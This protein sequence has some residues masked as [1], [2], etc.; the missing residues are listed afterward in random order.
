AA[1]TGVITAVVAA[2]CTAPFMAAAAGAA[3]LLAVPQALLVFAVM[4]LGLAFPYCT[5]AVS[6]SL[7]RRL[8]KPGPW[9]LRFRQALAFPMYATAAWLLWVLAEQAGAEA[10]LQA[11]LGIVVLAFA[12]WLLPLAAGWPRGVGVALA[13]LGSAMLLAHGSATPPPMNKTAAVSALAEPYSAARLAE[14][15]AEGRAVL[16][17]MTAAWCITCKVNEKIALSGES[18][19]E[20]L[21]THRIA[22][23]QGDWTVKNPDITA[24]LE[25]FGRAGVPLYVLYPTG[26]GEPKILP[27]LLDPGALGRALTS[28]ARLTDQG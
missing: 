21:K 18:F 2:P 13:L 6:P 3:V 22:Y 25:S 28:S 24:Y 23:L 27:Q 11:S 26:G 1:A 16:V 14:L 8:P 5:L 19:A 17:N 7:S 9:M 4:G 10:A 20:T 15:R 12:L